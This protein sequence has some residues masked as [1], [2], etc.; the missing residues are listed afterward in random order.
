MRGPTPKY[1][2][3]DHVR[4]F[5]GENAYVVSVTPSPDWEA[6]SHRVTVRWA[7]ELQNPDNTAYY[8]EV[9]EMVKPA[10]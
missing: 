2:P 7:D 5:R 8:E 6:K 1:K 3:G 4:S 10:E 9:F